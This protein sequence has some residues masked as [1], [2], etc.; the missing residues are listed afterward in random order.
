MKKIKYFIIILLI[1]FIGCAQDNIVDPQI[2]EGTEVTVSFEVVVPEYNIMKANGGVNDLHA[3]VFDENG[4]LIVRRQVQEI[5]SQTETGGV[6]KVTLPSS[7]TKRIVHFI[8]NYDWSTFNDVSQL[9]SN[10]ASVVALMSTNQAVFWS[11][12]VLDNGISE[13]SFQGNPVT[14]LRN[15]AKISVTSVATNFTY[16]GF[17]IHNT[18]EKGTVAP[19]NATT[20][21]FDENAISEPINVGLIPALQTNITTD[22]Q[23]LF[24]RK[25]KNASEITTVIVK[26]T[27]NGNSYFYKI[28]LIDSDKV[29]YNIQRNYHYVVKI[30]SV[31][32]EGYTN[33]ADALAGASHNNTALDP[34]IERY[35]MISD[36]FSKLEVERTLVIHTNVNQPF[37]VWYK[38]YPDI[39]SN[40]SNNDG[41]SVTLANDGAIADGTFSFDNT[42][43]TISATTA[44]TQSATPTEARIIVSKGNLART[45]R[46]ILRT[47]YSFS[48][49]TI[50][51]LNPAQL[52]NNQEV[53]A[54]LQ[55]FIPNDFPDELLPLSVN[56]YSQGLYPAEP[57]L[58]M[59]VEGGIIR[60]V[61]HTNTKGVQTVRFKTNQNN[62]AETVYIRSDYFSEGSIAYTRVTAK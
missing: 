19:F 48:P 51:D 34:I 61:H 42:T 3:L 20:L 29:R 33:F 17:T 60:Y 40:V 26:G 56:I 36:G 11:R 37:T 10:E 14:L 39:N 12:E 31:S 4:Y 8:S 27:F 32:K 47:P 43:G 25:N 62:F 57:G 58:E 53:N 22:E 5:V 52:I 21:Q 59:F 13:N 15:Q 23:Y 35:P 16:E 2:E 41:V 18:P 1:G 24:E 30:N 45:I 7:T 38:Y 9:G 44:S 50:N 54:A 55:Y 6:F 28:D 49:I 46:V